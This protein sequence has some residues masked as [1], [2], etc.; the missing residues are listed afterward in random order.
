[1]STNFDSSL[2]LFLRY[3]FIITIQN[4]TKTSTTHQ[5][6]VQSSQVYLCPAE[7]KEGFIQKCFESAQ[8]DLEAENLVDGHSF[9]EGL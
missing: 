4:M 9:S 2:F 3:P 8:K 1:M 5:D 6:Q 7:T